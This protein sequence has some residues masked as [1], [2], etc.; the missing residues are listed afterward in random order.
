MKK[1]DI[2]TIIIAVVIFI[3]AAGLIY[4]YFVPPPKDSGIK[5]EVPRPV[6][7]TFNQDQLNTLKNDVKDF[8]PD[9]TPKDSGNKPVIQ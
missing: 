7:P 8:S 3:V 9:L 5:V 4:R 6:S 2:I 1:R